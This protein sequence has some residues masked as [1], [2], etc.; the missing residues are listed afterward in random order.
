[1]SLESLLEDLRKELLA[2]RISNSISRINDMCSTGRTIRMSV[3]VEA[4]DDDIYIITTLK[5]CRDFINATLEKERSH[6]EQ[7]K[8]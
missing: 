1:M 4:T 6:R 8:Q 7:E 3:P 5:D 2:A